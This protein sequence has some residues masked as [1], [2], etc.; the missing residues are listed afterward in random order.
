ML[1]WKSSIINLIYPKQHLFRY[2]WA[3]LVSREICQ[4]NSMIFL[5]FIGYRGRQ[6]KASQ[7]MVSMNAKTFV[8]QIKIYFR[9]LQKYKSNKN[10]LIIT[11]VFFSMFKLLFYLEAYFILYY[12]RYVVKKSA[13]TTYRF[14][15]WLIFLLEGVWANY[16]FLMSM[17]CTTD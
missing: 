15:H 11:L 7:F 4:W 3:A 8:L 17:V 14:S 12:F 9:T 6:F 5:L 1:Y 10:I 2:K 13:R 16:K